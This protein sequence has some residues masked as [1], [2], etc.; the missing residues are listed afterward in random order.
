MCRGCD[1]RR[2]Q[3]GESVRMRD[4]V[5]GSKESTDSRQLRRKGVAGFVN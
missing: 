2:R 3:G 5:R 4:N 1:E